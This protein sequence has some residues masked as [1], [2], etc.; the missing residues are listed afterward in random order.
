MH[1]TEF[2]TRLDAHLARVDRRWTPQVAVRAHRLGVD[3][4]FGAPDLPFHA[5]SAGKLVTAALVA[6]LVEADAVRR[7]TPVA[8]LLPPEELAGLFAP[9][10]THM[11]TIEHLLTHTSG[12]ADY[13]EGKA[14]GGVRVAEA[15]TREPQRTWAPQELLAH[16]RERQRPVGRPGERFHYSDTGFVLLGRVLEVVTGTPFASLAHQRVFEPLGMARS[17]LPFR[18][19]PATGPTTIA[20]L[21]LGRTE[22]GR[23]PSITC[24]WAGGGIAATPGDLLRLTRAL[25]DGTLVSPGTWAWLAAP[26]NRFRAG[27]DY[28]AGTM[29]VRFEGFMPW[30]RGWPRLV[31][32]L[33]ITAAHVWHDPVHDANIVL[34]LGSTRALGPSFRA[35]F[36]VVRLLRRVAGQASTPRT[37][38]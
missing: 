34:N 37:S 26:R 12:V 28:G 19:E 20:P 5:A 23:F 27:L 31:G 35:L 38:P 30:L 33:G 15:A 16:T 10:T 7:D 6:Q 9:D 8:A 13:F 29:T 2:S 14:T 4:G 21:H 18:T 3:H 36:E 25:R 32:H 11:V 17:F 1:P 22:V 24:D